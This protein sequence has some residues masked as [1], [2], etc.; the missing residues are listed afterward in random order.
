[1]PDPNLDRP[2]SDLPQIIPLD[3]FINE[4]PSF[5]KDNAYNVLRGRYYVENTSSIHLNTFDS[6]A[7]LAWDDE[8]KM[9]V[10]V[11]E[12]TSIHKDVTVQELIDR[13]LLVAERYRRAGAM[14]IM[15]TFTENGKGYIVTYPYVYALKNAEGEIEY[16]SSTLKNYLQDSLERLGL[17]QEIW[18]FKREQFRKLYER[19]SDLWNS[20]LAHMDLK[21]TNI[22]I[23]D[24]EMFFI[25]LTFAK[26]LDD[27]KLI[28]QKDSVLG[29]AG[30]I[31]PERVRNKT[32]TKQEMLISEATSFVLT[33]LDILFKNP[34]QRLQNIEPNWPTLFAFTPEERWKDILN[35]LSYEITTTSI[36]VEGLP[37]ETKDE[38]YN[39]MERVRQIF[40]DSLNVDP[41]KRQP[42]GQF[43]DRVEAWFD[44]VIAFYE[45]LS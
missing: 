27:D 34:I 37:D 18:Q 12:I 11:K 13:E 26:K 15:A 6:K 9:L 42:I 45:Q 32:F 8:L 14:R 38:F 25:D 24:G 5:V 28:T 31:P 41:N 16:R 36:G 19:V 40:I 7:F 29:T 43:I 1:M 21:T 22:V 3:E 33:T 20:D 35:E 44:D 17:P 23:L 39:L 10:A 2:N 30:F 4:V